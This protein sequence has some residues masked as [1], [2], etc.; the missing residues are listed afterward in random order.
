MQVWRSALARPS[1]GAVLAG[2]DQLGLTETDPLFC[3]RCR[4]TERNQTRVGRQ[5]WRSESSYEEVGV[6]DPKRYPRVA[7][8]GR[9]PF[10]PG[11]GLIPPY[12]AGREAEQ[13]LL[14]RLLDV[15][16]EGSAPE[17]DVILYGPR[18]NGKTVLLEWTLREARRKN[19]ATVD[20]F[21]AGLLSVDVLTLSLF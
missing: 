18:G 15:I 11:Q 9:N 21:G 6:G 7:H 16:A 20:L 13:S 8:S 2:D 17:A 5:G 12:L 4:S 19:I 10:V 14:A 3:Y 1:D